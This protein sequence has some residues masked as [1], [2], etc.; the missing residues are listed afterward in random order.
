MNKLNVITRC[1]LNCM[2]IESIL[3]SDFGGLEY[4]NIEIENN[5]QLI[6]KFINYSNE[7]NFITDESLIIPLNTHCTIIFDNEPTEIDVQVIIG[8]ISFYCT[9][10]DLD[11]LNDYFKIIE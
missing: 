2:E 5:D 6:N 7:N 11:E 3:N 8:K 10:D 9:F 1:E 4:D